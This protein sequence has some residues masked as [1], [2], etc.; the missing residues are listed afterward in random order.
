M[1]RWL[2]GVAL[3]ALLIGCSTNAGR[4]IRTTFD[5]IFHPTKGQS[6][7]NAGLRQYDDGEYD[8]AAKNL[9]GALDLGLSERQQV[10]AYKHLAFIHCASNRERQCREEF[11]KALTVDPKLT[12]APEEAGHPVWGPIFRSVKAGR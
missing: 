4:S 12:L 8:E 3:A 11:R 7:L 9:Q 6:T 5:E 1:M 10:N 2:P